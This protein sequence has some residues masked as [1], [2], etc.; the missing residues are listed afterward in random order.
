[1]DPAERIQSDPRDPHWGGLEWSEWYSLEETGDGR[2][3]VPVEIG[4]Y[5]VRRTGS[6]ELIYVGISDT[7]RTRISQLRNASGHSAADCVAAHS[8]LGH[9]VEVSWATVSQM[10]IHQRITEEQR[11]ELLGLE[12]DLI[13]SCRWLFGRS[14]VCQHHG[15]PLGLLCHAYD[16]AISRRASISARF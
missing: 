4:I 14:P 3:L 11:R 9:I 16:N 10:Y 1:M 6:P 2:G 12:V 15:S 5:R 7:L 13:A 8:S